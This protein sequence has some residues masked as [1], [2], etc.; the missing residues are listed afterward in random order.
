MSDGFTGKGRGA[1]RKSVKMQARIR[2][3]GTPFDIDVV[4]LSPT[5]FRGETIY[6]LPIDA[7]IFVTLPGLSPLEAKVVWRD[8]AFVGCAFAAPLHPAV[9]DHIVARSQ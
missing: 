4:D 8:S 7:R 2:E 6:N 5:G 1:L 3:R 9:F